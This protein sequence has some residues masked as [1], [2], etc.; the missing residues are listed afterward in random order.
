MPRSH[1]PTLLTL[2]R[3][4]LQEECGVTRGEHILVAVSGGSD[5]TALLHALARLSASLGFRLTA[6]AVDHGLRQEAAREIEGA[7]ALAERLDVPFGATRVQVG[8]G[9]NLQAEARKARYAALRRA[10]LEVGAHYVATAHQAED[11]AETVLMR[12][13]RGAGPRGLS[14]LSPRTGFLL[15]PLIRVRKSAVEAHLERHGLEHASDPTN[16]DPRFLRTRVRGEL[17][18]LLESM[19]PAVVDHLN[20]LADAL[21]SGPPP[22][23]IDAN[24]NPV[25]LGRAQ[26]AALR[27]ANAKRSSRCRIRLSGGRELTI[28]A[29]TGSY[30]VVGPA[31]ERK[32]AD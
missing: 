14:V 22:T 12:L 28:D 29:K 9:G 10:M 24:G 15:R 19:A 16:R 32:G 20:M 6:H 2:V 1:P 3:R 8:S 17:L 4:T 30:R 11:R 13:L 31:G 25:P 27:R 23:I 26:I 7:R 18:P 5:S 21:A